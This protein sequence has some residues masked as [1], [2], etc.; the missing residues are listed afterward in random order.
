MLASPAALI[1]LLAFFAGVADGAV[2][3]IFAHLALCAVRIL[4]LAAALNL[5]FLGASVGSAGVD[6]SPPRISYSSF[7]SDSMRSWISAA[8]RSCDGVALIMMVG[9]WIDLWRRSSSRY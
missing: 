7:C 3:L 5:R 6:T 8:L 2:P 9:V 1:F 4:A